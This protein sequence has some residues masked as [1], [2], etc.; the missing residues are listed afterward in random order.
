MSLLGFSWVKWLPLDLVG[1][2]I[3][4]RRFGFDHLIFGIVHS[5]SHSVQIPASISSLW[6][7]LR[8]NRWVLLIRN[9]CVGSVHKLSILLQRFVQV[10][11]L[12]NLFLVVIGSWVGI[13]FPRWTLY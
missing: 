10:T 1:C 2:E 5:W 7:F 4:L 9:D 11:W 8:G 6:H 13:V 3:I 12:I